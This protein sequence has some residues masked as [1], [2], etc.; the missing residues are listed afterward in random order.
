MGHENQGLSKPVDHSVC[1]L[2]M[3]QEGTTMAGGILG[4][5]IRSVIHSLH[6][7]SIHRH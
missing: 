6:S 3:I 1:K 4:H 7:E 5:R 2:D